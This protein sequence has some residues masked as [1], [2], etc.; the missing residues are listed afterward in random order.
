MIAGASGAQQVGFSLL[1]GES[2]TVGDYTLQFTGLIGS[3]PS[4]DLYY[5]G[6][7]VVRFPSPV[8]PPNP[9]E[10]WYENVSVATT[11]VTPDGTATGLMTI[12]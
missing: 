9:H 1:V 11:E 4:Y 8:P 2:V 12:Q 5:L 3:L 6:K 7:L 10:Y